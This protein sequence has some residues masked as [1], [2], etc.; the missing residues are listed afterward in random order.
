MADPFVEQLKRFCR[1]H[2]YRAKWVLVP[3][4]SLGWTLGE[5]LVLEGCDWVNLRFTTPFQLALEAAAPH[6]LGQGIH[7]CPDALGPGLL[8]NL[9]LA[10]P[11]EDDGHFRPLILQPGL[12]QALWATLSEF[13]LTGLPAEALGNL[14]YTPKR[15]ELFRLFSAYE[16]HLR[17]QN[18][19]DRADIL[20]SQVPVTAITQEDLIVGY[21][22]CCWTPLE[23]RFLQQ[24]PGQHQLP[25]AT[26][27]N[28]PKWWP[29]RQPVA[30]H[31]KAPSYF[32]TLR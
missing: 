8:Q 3:S 4:P 23:D 17:S 31:P 12:A 25:E 27:Q 16:S 9:L 6:L 24:L 19:A 28:T 32:S 13:R 2:P 29:P 7:P 21:P 1:E 15:R 26:A 22:Y 14:P 30:H 18:W 11:E 5:R 20:S 10:L